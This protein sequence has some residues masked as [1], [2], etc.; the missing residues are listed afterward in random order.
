MEKT[1]IC[2]FTVNYAHSNIIT[3]NFIA[4]ELNNVKVIYMDERVGEKKN[5]ITDEY[6]RKMK[7]SNFFTER[8][9]ENIVNDY[10]NEKFVFIINGS[11]KFIEKTNEYLKL[12]KFDGYIIDSYNVFDKELDVEKIMNEHDYYINTSG[13]I[14]KRKK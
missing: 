9:N 4:N 14:K 12:N 7:D 10:E 1:K 6:Y 11:K 3:S 2:C 13:L 5:K 8:L